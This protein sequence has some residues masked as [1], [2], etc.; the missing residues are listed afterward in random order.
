M[1]EGMKKNNERI[2]PMTNVFYL[3]DVHGLP[4]AGAYLLAEANR[5]AMREDGDDG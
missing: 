4:V 1:G 5:E 2:D 3:M